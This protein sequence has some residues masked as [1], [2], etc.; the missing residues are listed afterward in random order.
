VLPGLQILDIEPDRI[1]FILAG[2]QAIRSQ[3]GA[4]EA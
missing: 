3:A 4:V 1:A 2:L